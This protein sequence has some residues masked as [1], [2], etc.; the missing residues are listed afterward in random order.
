M[1]ISWREVKGRRVICKDG[2]YFSICSDAELFELKKILEDM[3]SDDPK[4]ILEDPRK[5]GKH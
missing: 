2:V 5:T 4:M 3:Q 1:S